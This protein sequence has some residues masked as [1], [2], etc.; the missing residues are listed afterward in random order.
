MTDQDVNILN[1][2]VRAGETDEDL[3][4]GLKDPMNLTNIMTN[5]YS[6]EGTFVYGEDYDISKEDFKTEVEPGPGTGGDEHDKDPDEGGEQEK[7]VTDSEIL[8]AFQ[9]NEELSQYLLE[10]SRYAVWLDMDLSNVANETWYL[11]TTEDGKVDGF[12]FSFEYITG[13]NTYYE[14][15]SIKFNTPVSKINLIA[16]NFDMKSLVIEG[17]YTLN[18]NNSIQETKKELTNAIFEALGVEDTGAERFI[19][20]RSC[21]GVGDPDFGQYNSYT[22]V[23]ITDSLITEYKVTIKYPNGKPAAEQVKK[24]NIRKDSEKTTQ[25]EGRK[26]VADYAEVTDAELIAALRKNC[27]TQLSNLFMDNY[28]LTFNLSKVENDSWYIEEE[29]NNITGGT[30]TLFYNRSTSSRYFIAINLTLNKSIS[31][32]DLVKNNLEGVTFNLSEIYHISYNPAIQADNAELTD[33]I[34]DALGVEDT[35]ATRIIIDKGLNTYEHELGQCHAY[36]VIQIGDG[37]ILE[38]AIN[39][40]VSNDSLI[41][42]LDKNLFHELVDSR[43]TVEIEGRKLVA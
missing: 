16:G 34:F 1:F 42:N 24:G 29:R 9:A 37:K 33:A 12:D 4:N 35:G 39:I 14:F 6:L 30:Y 7:E 13:T 8:H 5:K 20:E 27:E 10:N 28:E 41:T 31:K 23:Q 38:Y 43:K 18:Y 2:G 25:I 15:D 36:K 22:V 26:L 21:G 19:I 3:L 17:K 11:S 40:K 32:N